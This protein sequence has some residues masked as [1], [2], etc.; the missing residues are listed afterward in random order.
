MNLELF[1][2]AVRGAATGVML[3]FVAVLWIKAAPRDIRLA[4]GL[5]VIATTCRTWSGLPPGS[6]M[7]QDIVLLL[8][9][10][11]A[12]AMTFFTWAFILL[13]VDTRRHLWLW[14]GSAALVTLGLWASATIPAMRDPTRVYA[15]L[16]VF[17]LLATIVHAQRDDLI[18]RRRSAR[19]WVAL[20]VIGYVLFAALFSSPMQA[21]KTVIVPLTQSVLQLFASTA[22]TLW[23]IT[24]DPKSWVT[25]TERLDQNNR[26]DGL[27]SP[28]VALLRRIE[29]AMQNEIWRREGLTV[30]GLAQ[31]VGAPE[32]Q[33]RKAINQELGY[34]NFSSFINQSRIA[35]AKAHLSD[36]AQA[37]TTVQEIAYSVGFSSIGP[38]NRAFRDI[39][40]QSPSVFR[41]ERHSTALADVAAS[42]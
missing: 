8:K 33:V 26:S 12:T 24:L 1:D 25:A 19:V 36:P 38:F 17:A 34:R 35:A 18:D 7:P 3:I 14:L 28:Q 21:E 39:I 30:A 6:E 20:S 11:G 27:I 31:D 15:L 42:V 10:T 2:V 32:H 37:T 29:T 13:F 4:F 41:K 5:T 16:H 22:F 9:L 23:A 40:G